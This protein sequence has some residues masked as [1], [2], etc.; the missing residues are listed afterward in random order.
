MLPLA[1][2]WFNLTKPFRLTSLQLFIH[3]M[4]YVGG[5]SFS[6][7]S[8][9]VGV[10]CAGVSVDTVVLLDTSVSLLD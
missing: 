10:C 1:G 6:A 8:G 5:G 3:I 9:G 7:L 2:W 4:Y